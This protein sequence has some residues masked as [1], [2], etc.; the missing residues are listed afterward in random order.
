M[1]AFRDLPIRHKL[2]VVIMITSASALLVGGAASITYEYFRYRG[3][4]VRDLSTQAEIVADATAAAL[5]FDDVEAA[6][7]GLAALAGRRAIVS[8][9][10]YRLDGRLFAEYV[11]PG[12]S[13]PP[14]PLSELPEGYRFEGNRLLLRRRVTLG[15]DRVGIISLRADLRE[16]RVRLI[17]YAAIATTV[18]LA[19]LLGALVLSTRLQRII[20]EPILRLARLTKA[21]GEKQDFSVRADKQADDEIGALTDGFNQM[22]AAVEQREQTLEASE[23]RFRQL[24]ENIREVFWMTN[25]DKTEMIYVSPA[26][27]EIWGR[28][29]GELY[30]EPRSWL[31]AIHP[32]D[33]RRVEQAALTKQT[34]GEYDEQYRVVR[35]DGSVRWI[36]DRAFPISDEAGRVYRIAG[37][38]ED[39]TGRKLVEQAIRESEERLQAI[40]DNSTAVIYLKDRQ[41]R[42]LHINRWYETVFHV[43]REQVIGKTDYNI[44]PKER[45]DAF[46]INDLEVLKERRPM[47]F[48]EVAPQ[49]D[50]LHTYI[51]IKFPLFDSA[52]E[53][54]AVCGISTDIT[55][56]KRTEQL[57]RVRDGVSRALAEAP[58]LQEAAPKIIRAFCKL[59]GWDAGAIWAVDAAANK[60]VC[61]EFWHSPAVAFPAFEADTRQRTFAP[62]IGLP[63]RVWSSGKPAWIA[64]VTQ[65]NNFPRR[66]VAVKDGLHAGVCFP[67]TLGQQVLGVMECFSREVRGPD[68]NFVR[69]LTAIGAL[70]GQFMERKRLE[71]EILEIIER[72]Q[73]RIGQDLHD[74]LSQHL[75]GTALAC[76]TLEQ[77]LADVS[78]EAAVEAGE[79]AG[80]IDRAITQ[81]KQLARGLYPVKLES[82]GLSSALKELAAS[83]TSRFNVA[84]EVENGKPVL[85]ADNSVA[86]HL[87]RIAQEAITNAIKHSRAQ[88]IVIR[89]ASADGRIELKVV[90][91]GIGIDASQR[92]AGG[93]GLDIM[94]YRARMIGGSLA[95]ER[96]GGGGTVISC[97]VPQKPG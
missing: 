85:V 56:R 79:I 83:V 42:Y 84:V 95:I 5:A 27:E 36:R 13:A 15:G 21:V 48:E 3:A 16:Q 40:M 57:L 30:T 17:S 28:R 8:A 38:A 4:M 41:G 26:Y 67:I 65:D 72:E 69:T 7:E 61:S 89:L 92:R 88:R 91:D 66:P 37:I 70:L 76:R 82:E 73:A 34:S 63:G 6:Q 74:D 20:S 97:C 12:V 47:E 45:A 19:L 11:Q 23:E 32:D 22:L 71:K 1:K 49:D 77:S 54:C 39:I 29:L 14:V 87:Y 24:A 51:S 86:T 50:G 53:P 62:G 43:R 55:E 94:E 81:A 75:F 90:D 60:L 52:G 93:M 33:R 2:T 25:L 80:L 68:A 9:R 58:T 64:D 35:P 59:A 18:M 46:R 10:L 96:N 31:A 44:F 78:P